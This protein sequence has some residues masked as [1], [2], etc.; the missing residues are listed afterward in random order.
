MSRY[1][2]PSEA[3]RGPLYRVIPDDGRRGGKKGDFVIVRPLWPE[4]YVRIEAYPTLAEAQAAPDELNAL[5]PG[6]LP[7]VVE[8]D[9]AEREAKPIS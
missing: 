6:R 4:L 8:R 3:E 5:Y 9:I 1:S 2:A 7:V